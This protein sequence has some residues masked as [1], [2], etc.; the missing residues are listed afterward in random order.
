MTGLKI[1]CHSPHFDN[2]EADDVWIRECAKRGWVIV[3]SD[4]NIENDPINRQAVVDSKARIF[5]LEE[6][7]VRA[8]FWAAAI[9]VSKLRI[10]E[11][12]SLNIGP[13]F[14]NIRKETG[15]L[16]GQI[17]Q[18]TAELPTPTLGPSGAPDDQVSP[19]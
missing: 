17:R 12:I 5:F 3:T 11:I 10:Y 18:P 8:I 9:I 2:E 16:V 14:A 1:E 15:F 7:T 6:G 19:S 13:F 4:K